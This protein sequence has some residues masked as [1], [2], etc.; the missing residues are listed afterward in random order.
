MD[1]HRGAERPGVGATGSLGRVSSVE[2]RARASGNPGS[3]GTS[4]VG[5]QAPPAWAPPALGSTDAAPR[6]FLAAL[7]LWGCCGAGRAGTGRAQSFPRLEVT[8]ELLSHPLPQLG[9]APLAFPDP[10]GP[11]AG[12]KHRSEGGGEG[13]QA[14]R[15]EGWGAGCR[16]GDSRPRFPHLENGFPLDGFSKLPGPEA[17]GTDHTAQGPAQKMPVPNSPSR[18]RQA[19]LHPWPGVWGCTA[20]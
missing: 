1:P 6:G 14:G 7:Q 13:L 3:P 16:L 10:A 17:R 4:G 18:W 11:S 8:K 12:D 5:G 20:G 19:T 15:T 2:P 9:R